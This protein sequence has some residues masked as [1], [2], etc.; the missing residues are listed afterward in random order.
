MVRQ[1][2][3]EKEVI[4]SGF[5]Q[6]IANILPGLD[7]LA[8]CSKDPDPCPLVSLEAAA[9]AKAIISSDCGGTR[10][11][12]AEGKQALFYRAGNYRQLAEK[13]I[14]LE[15]NRPLRESLGRAA[16]IQVSEQHNLDIFLSRIK[17]AV[18]RTLDGK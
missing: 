8:I 10:E 5:R 3:L 9:M 16:Q 18:Q 6:D 1:L 17:N 14:T 2:N 11:I 7:I 12:F 13:I 15:E 4:F